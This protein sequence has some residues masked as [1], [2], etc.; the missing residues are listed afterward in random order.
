[1][2]RASRSG[3]GLRKDKGSLVSFF[4]TLVKSSARLVI[5]LGVRYNYNYIQ[6]G[7]NGQ[8]VN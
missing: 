6:Y 2:Y 1:M 5:G 4:R 3:P 8:H 7:F